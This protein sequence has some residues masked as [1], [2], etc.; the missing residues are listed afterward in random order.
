[1][2]TDPRVIEIMVTDPQDLRAIEIMVTDLQDLRAIDLREIDLMVRTVMARAADTRIEMVSLHT[3]T[4]KIV[5]AV[6]DLR[7]TDL[8]D[9]RATDLLTRM[10]D[11]VRV[12]SVVETAWE[13]DPLVRMALIRM[14]SIKMQDLTRETA[15]R[16]LIRTKVS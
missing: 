13:T 4:E 7:V 5:L 15:L 12:V 2:V 3:V 11:P 9:L 14:H 16:N 1:M 8:Q 6:T 10:A